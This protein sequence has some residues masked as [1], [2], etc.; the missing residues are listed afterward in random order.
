MASWPL[1]RRTN[2]TLTGLTLPSRDLDAV[3]LHD[4]ADGLLLQSCRGTGQ[5]DEGSALLCLQVERSRSFSRHTSPPPI[6]RTP[7]YGAGGGAP[8]A[9]DVGRLRRDSGDPVDGSDALELGGGLEAWHLTLAPARRL[10]RDLGAVVRVLNWTAGRR[11]RRDWTRI[12]PQLCS[13]RPQRDNAH[14]AP[15][16]GR[17]LADHRRLSRLGLRQRGSGCARDRPAMLLGQARKRHLS[18]VV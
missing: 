7:A 2:L 5:L 12:M 17:R 10:I 14:H 1:G 11:F 13:P 8:T 16:R 4:L 3:S 18:R 15:R 9:A 6:R